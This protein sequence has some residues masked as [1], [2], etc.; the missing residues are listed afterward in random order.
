MQNFAKCFNDGILRKWTQ[1]R[2]YTSV[3]RC[4]SCSAAVPG[5]CGA[6]VSPAHLCSVSGARRERICG[7]RTAEGGRPH[8]IYIS[9]VPYFLVPIPGV[10]RNQ[11]QVLQQRARIRN[12]FHVPASRA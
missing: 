1:K 10:D 11:L 12:K 8:I 6:S 9:L 4:C 5:G 2:P 3:L 7:S